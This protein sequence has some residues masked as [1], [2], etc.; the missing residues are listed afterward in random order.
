VLSRYG[1]PAL[2]RFTAAV[3]V[4]LLLHLLRIPFVLAARVLEISL[5]RIKDYAAQQATQPPR[6]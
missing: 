4:F 1:T 3:A 6:G 2:L 5:H